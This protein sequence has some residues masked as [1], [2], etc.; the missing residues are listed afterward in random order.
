MPSL[1][2]GRPIAEGCQASGRF[3]ATLK[4]LRP[5]RI[6]PPDRYRR[7]TEGRRL[8]ARCW[9]LAILIGVAALSV[10]ASR[11]SAAN[12]IDLG[13]LGGP[14][15]IAYGINDVGQIVGTSATASGTSHAFLWSNGTMADLGSLGSAGPSDGRGINNRG[16]VVGGTVD[17][18]NS[19]YHAFLWDHGTMSDL[20]TLRGYNLSQAQAINDA[21]QVV[22]FS[23]D[24]S[25]G[26]LGHAFLWDNG[27]MSDLGTLPGYNYSIALGIN[28]AGQVAGYSF[29]A[30]TQ[31]G[32]MTSRAFLWDNGNMSDLGTLPQAN[33][34]E[35]FG[36]NDFGAVVGDSG[37]DSFDGHGVLWQGG[38]VMDLG[39]LGRP[40][41]S[42]HAINDAGQIVGGSHNFESRVHAFLWE[43]G[44]MRDLGSLGQFSVAYD[45]NE[46][47]AAVGQTDVGN[48][49][50][51]AAL[52]PSSLPVH[53]TATIGAQVTPTSV[54]AGTPVTVSGTVQNQGSQVE[55]FQVNVT[56]GGVLVGTVSVSLPSGASR[57][58][59]F[60]WNTSGVAP[61]PYAVVMETAPL[62]GETDLGDNALA[63]G[64]VTIAPRPVFAEASAT[65]LATDV[66]LRISFTCRGTD[67]TPPYEFAWDFG[68]GGNASTQTATHAYSASG[69]KTARCT[70]TDREQQQA[71]AEIQV[72][73][74][75]AL[76]ILA[77]VNRMAVAPAIPLTFSALTTGGTGAVT[78]TWVFGDNSGLAGTPVTHAYRDPG[79]YSVLVQARDDAGG[80]VSTSL[81]VTIAEL[82]VTGTSNVTS[83]VPGAAITFIS[84]ASGGSGAPY[85]YVWDFG[86]GSPKAA[87]PIVTHAYAAGR[88]TPS[89]TVLDGS[90]ASHTT[91]LPII[92]VENQPV[93]V[94]SS[95]PYFA[96]G[97]TTAIIVGIGAAVGL[98]VRRR[99]RRKSWASRRR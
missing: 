44:I 38:N 59:S 24:P 20:G 76:A 95:P 74:A 30:P 99:R 84:V 8:A 87:G 91:L 11:A 13:T 58:L 12:I 46:T 29:T 1:A 72:S 15:S 47:G 61:G 41:T 35:A 92:T 22:G 19:Q 53:D 71:S 48:G 54:I 85:T 25:M 93:T 70:V 94:L 40:G 2:F 82:L 96:I 86:D 16:Q 64:T 6:A 78:I 67:G 89:V 39:D 68:D 52:W 73:V 17:A 33:D 50:L 98:M 90:G 23:G 21:G 36:L 34:S 60:V 37:N 27:T 97:L 77:T 18:N 57:E 49:E 42:A 9:A 3:V 55:T 88:F 32:P 80:T 10:A 51:H 4:A 62:A 26:G 66:D 75:P 83:T 79:Q 7:R 69:S 28:D 65:P 14:V 5:N 63:A 45:V 81:S 31:S 56:A 43:F